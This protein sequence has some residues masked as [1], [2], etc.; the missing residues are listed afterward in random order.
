MVLKQQRH[1]V[2][3]ENEPIIGYIQNMTNSGFVVLSEK[4]LCDQS[5]IR[6]GV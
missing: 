1:C 4:Q 3:N 5:K 6:W 2:K